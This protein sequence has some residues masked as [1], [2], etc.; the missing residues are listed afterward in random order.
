M[1]NLP[2]HSIVAS[3]TKQFASAKLQQFSAQ[4]IVTPLGV[5]MTWL[6]VHT[7]LAYFVLLLGAYF[8]ALVGPSFFIPG[9]IFLL[10]GSILAGSR[11]LNIW[12][13]AGVLY[14]GAILGDTSSYWIGRMI[15]T[16]IFHEDKKF[17][18]F[19]N[20]HKVEA[21]LEKYGLI[22]I[23][24]A[25]LIG[26]FSKLAPVTAGIF[27]IPFKKFL[28]HNIPGVLV[29]CG[30][31][32]VVGYFFGNKYELVLWV[33]ERYTAAIAIVIAL[34]AGGYWYFLKVRKSHRNHKKHSTASSSE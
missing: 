30:E 10:G 3:S 15:G 24:F 14:L 8:E 27:E 32:I 2:L 34:I 29:G 17:L 22:G 20:Y 5:F 16:S 7:H 25:R 1:P 28:L 31:F 18:N 23:F 11:I 6:S 4:Y 33:I 19:K 9:E 26:P 12:L 21:M 13:V